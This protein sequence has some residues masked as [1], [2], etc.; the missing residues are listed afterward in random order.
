ME[1]KIELIEKEKEG[2]FEI[3][4]GES[5]LAELNFRKV[6]PG[7]IDAYHTFVDSSLR[8]QGIADKLYE[9]LR[10]YAEERKLEIVATCSYIA[11]KMQQ[12]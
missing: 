10:A 2:V 1:R 11:K 12:S 4:E 6:A 9:A 3:R 5:L 7:K 8:G